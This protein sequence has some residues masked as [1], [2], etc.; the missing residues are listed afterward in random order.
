V[1]VHWTHRLLA[2]SLA[3]YVL[4][5]AVKSRSRAPRYL[6]ALV[7]AQVAVAAAM[8]LLALPKVLQAAHVAVGAGLWAG[9]VLAAL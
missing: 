6:L 4:V 2:Y 7:V 9:L 8:V 1:H 3:A 5:W